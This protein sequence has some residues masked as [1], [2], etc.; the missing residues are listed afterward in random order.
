MKAYCREHGRPCAR[1]RQLQ[2]NIA[3]AFAGRP[4][5]YVATDE[6]CGGGVDAVAGYRITHTRQS[7]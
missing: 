4:R 7:G 6:R 2:G 3:V 1:D 5:G